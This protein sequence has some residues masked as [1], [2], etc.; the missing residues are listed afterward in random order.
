MRAWSQDLQR[1]THG[2]YKK[3]SMNENAHTQNPTPQTWSQLLQRG[4]NESKEIPPHLVREESMSSTSFAKC[5]LC[6][7]IFGISTYG[8]RRKKTQLIW[9]PRQ[10][11][12]FFLIF[13]NWS[14]VDLKC[15]RCTAKWF[16][17]THTCVCIYIYTHAYIH[18]YSFSGSFPI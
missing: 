5:F 7:W 10:I 15:F 9:S 14:I 18:I 17:Y 12:F 13:K 6:F 2:G 3:H 1:L 8:Y 16:G 4:R 11:L